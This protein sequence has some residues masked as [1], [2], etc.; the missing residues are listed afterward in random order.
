M[1]EKVIVFKTGSEMLFRA[2][3]M[4]PRHWANKLHEQLLKKNVYERAIQPVEYCPVFLEKMEIGCRHC[5]NQVKPDWLEKRSPILPYVS[6]DGLIMKMRHAT[7]NC[8]SCGSEVLIDI[9]LVPHKS[10][11]RFYGDE[12]LRTELLDK[13]IV[14]YT[15]VGEPYEED[16][17]EDLRRRFLNLKRSLIPE[18]D[19][20]GWV[21]HF[22]EL[23]SGR[24]KYPHTK[25]LNTS[26][27]RTFA[28][29]LGALVSAFENEL[30]VFNSAGVF[31]KPSSFKGEEEKKLKSRVVYPLLMNCLLS[32]TSEGYSPHF[33]FERSNTDGWLGNLF[34]GSMLTLAWPFITHSNPIPEIEF[35]KPTHDFLLE[36]ADFISFVIARYLLQ[37]GRGDES[38]IDFDPR[39]LG[40][41]AYTGFRSDGGALREYKRGYP[42][43]EFFA[44]TSWVHGH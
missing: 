26:Q 35:V 17:K 3:N 44:G 11:R 8:K 30:V 43:L 15:F 22:K 2:A 20:T 29:Q 18:L 37:V 23:W 24:E 12:A 41:I 38:K 40:L 6:N 1:G 7:E 4:D 9:P 33:F 25:K 28:D 5:G 32:H 16:V 42:L 19:P 39:I 31:I 21:L 36:I 34:R 14:T 13:V 10:M 27:V